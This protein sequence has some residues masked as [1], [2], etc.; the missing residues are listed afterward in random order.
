MKRDSLRNEVREGQPGFMS[1]VSAC[2]PICKYQSYDLSEL[3]GCRVV[4]RLPLND[5]FQYIEAGYPLVYDGPLG[6]PTLNACTTETS[7]IS[8]SMRTHAALIG[9]HACS[10]SACP[11]LLD[12]DVKNPP[13][14]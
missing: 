14:D 10:T 9:A 6:H 2:T 8:R 1:S 7:Q 3:Q 5:D 13:R 12:G 11:H 4:L